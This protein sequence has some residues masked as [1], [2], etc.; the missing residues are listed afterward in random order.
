MKISDIQKANDLL[1]AAQTATGVLNGINRAKD[2]A[3]LED[4]ISYCCPPELMEQV[5][6]LFRK[7]YEE[8]LAKMVQAMNEFGLEFTEA[9]LQPKPRISGNTFASVGQFNTTGNVLATKQ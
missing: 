9:D 7:R 3:G 4:A 8:S 2:L 5:R 1:R 6:A